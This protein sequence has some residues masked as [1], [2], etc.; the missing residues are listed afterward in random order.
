MLS[1]P[2]IYLH[3]MLF[4]EKVFW[5]IGLEL[6]VKYHNG[7]NLCRGNIYISIYESMSGLKEQ[8]ERG[9]KRHM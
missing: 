5:A 9:N 2:L 7:K 1:S 3:E 8:E 6:Y 4:E